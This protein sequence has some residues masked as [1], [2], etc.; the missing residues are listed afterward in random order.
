MWQ[1]S[2]PSYP[3]NVKK[4]GTRWLIFDSLRR[5][6]VAL[7][8]EE[9][10]RQHFLHY[11]IHEKNYPAS[12]IA[13]EQQIVVNGQHKRCDAILYNKEMEAIA[14]FEFKAPYVPI[15]QSTFDQAAVYN[16]KLNIHNIFL[17]NGMNH[18]FYKVS[19]LQKTYHI[20]TEIPDFHQLSHN[21]GVL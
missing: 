4:N 7:T 9:W 13:V 19:P 14:I 20:Q 18:Y 8:P 10:V 3:Y 17:S 16:T 6:F 12:L 5:R 1:L 15:T 2:L 21:S 11:I